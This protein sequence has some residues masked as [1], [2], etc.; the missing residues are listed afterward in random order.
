MLVL[1]VITN[2]S[3][4]LNSAPESSDEQEGQAHTVFSLMIASATTL[5][6]F[7]A[8]GLS[9]IRVV[10]AVGQT[11]VVGIIVGLAWLAPGGSVVSKDE[12]DID[13]GRGLFPVPIEA[14]T[15]SVASVVAAGRS[16]M[17]FSRRMRA[18]KAIRR[19]RRRS[20]DVH[21]PRRCRQH[22]TY[23]NGSRAGIAA[24]T[25]WHGLPCT[26]MTFT[27]TLRR[28]QVLDRR[29]SAFRRHQY[30]R[31][32]GYG[33]TLQTLAWERT[34]AGPLRV[35]TQPGF[36]QRSRCFDTGT[37]GAATLRVDRLLF[38][39][40]GVRSRGTLSERRSV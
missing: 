1:G 35:A 26:R 33:G 32:A 38:E 7:G 40:K 36:G 18:G 5:A 21:R 3:L 12:V 13:P 15:A 16:P 4:F 37:R 9:G 20:E 39:R 28:P 10:E 17:R 29:A 22:P 30:L 24:I 25:A 23:L 11:V 6:V 31:I 19:F 8:L 2:Y 14:F 27:S 34:R